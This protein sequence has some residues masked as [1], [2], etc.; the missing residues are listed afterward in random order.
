MGCL[1]PQTTEKDKFCALLKELVSSVPSPEQKRGRPQ[2]PLSDLIFAACFKVYSTVSARRFMSD[3]RGASADGLIDKLPHYNSIFNVLDKESLTPTSPAPA[4]YPRRAAA[5]LAGNR[6]RCGLH[7]LWTPE[8]LSPL[9]RQVRAR[10]GTTRLPEDPRHRRH[11]DKRGCRRR[12]Y[13]PVVGDSPM[14]SPLVT[15]AS[16]HFNGQRVSADKAYASKLN[17]ELMESLGV[18]PFVPF[19]ENNT[20]NDSPTWNRLFHFLPSA[21]RRISGQLSSALERRI[22][23]LRDEAETRR[24]DPVEIA[25]RAEERSADEGARA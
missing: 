22:D 12:R 17:F 4:H 13:G 2:L 1:Q 15:E 23:V 10:C 25:S 19:K 7:R 6:L 18:Q 16:D 11:A 5:P 14:L 9:Q 8:L 20:T 24:H 3:L 21:P